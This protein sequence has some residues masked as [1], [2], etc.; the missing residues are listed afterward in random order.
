MKNQPCEL[1]C[2]R[3]D[4]SK[5]DHQHILNHLIEKRTGQTTLVGFSLS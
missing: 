1:A 3:S 4:Y 2:L 5:I